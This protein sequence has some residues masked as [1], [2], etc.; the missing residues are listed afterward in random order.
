MRNREFLL[1]LYGPIYF[2]YLRLDDLLETFSKMSHVEKRPFIAEHEDGSRCIDKLVRD[3]YLKDYGSILKI[4]SE[5]LLFRATGGYTR[6]FLEAK[7][8]SAS[9]WISIISFLVACT[10]FVISLTK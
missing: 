4:T 1:R 2:E 6:E 7:R 9:F 5:G 8:S 10:S 3:G